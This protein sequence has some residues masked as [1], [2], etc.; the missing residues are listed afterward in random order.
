MEED[1]K[2]RKGVLAKQ[3]SINGVDKNHETWPHVLIYALNQ[4]TLQTLS[5]LFL[6]GK[7][8]EIETP[9]SKEGWLLGFPLS[10][11]VPLARM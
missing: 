6:G 10:V 11:K 7:E 9:S 3:L 4:T 1:A 5:Y 2:G 8:R